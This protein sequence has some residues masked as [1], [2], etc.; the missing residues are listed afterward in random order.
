MSEPE[1]S[2]IVRTEALTGLIAELADQ[3]VV[4]HLASVKGPVRD[5]LLRDGLYQTLGDRVH[6]HV[7]DA[8]R[9]LQRTT[10][11]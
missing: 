6:D 2:P 5:V 4:V 10:E 9:T 3:D 11:R 1:P 8:V 7:D